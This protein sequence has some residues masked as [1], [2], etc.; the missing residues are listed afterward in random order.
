MKIIL[1]IAICLLIVALII[2][3]WGILTHWTFKCKKKDNYKKISEIALI[4]QLYNASSD[5]KW[6][7]REEFKV[8]NQK[9]LRFQKTL[10]DMAE[11][12]DRYDVEYFLFGGTA[13]G[14]H[15]EGKFIQ[16]DHDIDLAVFKQKGYLK[17][18]IQIVKRYPET[19]TLAR[20]FPKG[21]SLNKITEVT[22]RHVKTKI[23]LDIFEVEK[24]KN[25]YYYYTYTGICDAR[26]KGRCV[27]KLKPFKLIKK[28][29][30]GKMYRIPPRSYLRDNYGKTW[31]ILQKLSYTDIVSRFST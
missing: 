9:Q 3:V 4:K 10:E 19:F 15:R 12:L 2:V 1:I 25:H 27:F 17:K 26:P 29:F 22:F 16:H 7:Y 28:A 30:M 14:C 21:Q 8:L 23:N 18:I 13:L 5:I 6:P 11:I 24:L 31:N 20:T